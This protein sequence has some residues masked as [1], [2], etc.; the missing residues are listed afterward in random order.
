MDEFVQNNYDPGYDELFEKFRKELYDI[1]EKEVQKVIKEL[2][3]ILRSFINSKPVLN[4]FSAEESIDKDDFYKNSEFLQIRETLSLYFKA[5]H[6]KLSKPMRSFVL[7][8]VCN[9]LDKYIIEE[10]LKKFKFTI[11]GLNFVQGFSANLIAGL[12]EVDYELYTEK[13]TR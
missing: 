5:A 2:K 8:E 13:E 10:V 1:L 9:Q 7:A 4:A 6:D 3:K 11:L 12:K